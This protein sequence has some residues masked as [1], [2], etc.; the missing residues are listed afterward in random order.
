MPIEVELKARVTNHGEVTSRLARHADAEAS[1]YRDTYYDWPDS[2]FERDGRRE[3]RVRIVENDAGSRVVLTYKAPMLDETS[4]P[5]YETT[6]GDAPTFD[7]IL[8]GLGLVPTIAFEKHCL[9]Y[10]F[11]AY[12]HEI[13][14]TVV[15]VPE[16]GDEVFVEIETLVDTTS[17]T[18]KATE[19]IQQVLTDLRLTK[20]DLT[21]ELYTDRIKQQRASH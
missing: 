11:H 8:T 17:D 3:L 16:L 1:I 15:R 12:D 4:T 5:E 13:T 19:A 14:T 20:Y 2:R 9:N 10:R 21:D 7:A 18:P 6:V